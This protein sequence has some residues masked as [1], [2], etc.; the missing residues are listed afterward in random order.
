MAASAPKLT[1]SAQSEFEDLLRS[2]TS[3][4]RSKIDA[5][6]KLALK[7]KKWYKTVVH[8]LEKYIKN[9]KTSRLPALY[10]IDSIIRGSKAKFGV[11]DPYAD[12]FSRKLVK[13]IDSC[14]M[15]PADQPNVKKLVFLW[16]SKSWFPAEIMQPI[17]AKLN[18]LGQRANEKKKLAVKAGTPCKMP[19]DA[20]QTSV[21]APVI[22]GERRYSGIKGERRYSG[23]NG[24]ED[25]DYGS[26]ED[27][28]SLERLKRKREQGEDYGATRRPAKKRRASG[29]KDDGGLGLFSG[30][31][32]MFGA[33][34]GA[35][36]D[37][38]GEQP[39]P[40]R[41]EAEDWMHDPNAEEEE[42]TAAP[43]VKKEPK[44][45]PTDDAPDP[46]I[47]SM[48]LVAAQTD[49]PLPVQAV[50]PSLLPAPNPN[51][52]YP[53]HNS[54]HPGGHN[55][56]H[57]QPTIGL[58]AYEH[59]RATAEVVP[60]PQQQQQP[61][62]FDP[63][64]REN[65]DQEHCPASMVRVKSCTLLLRHPDINP[66]HSQSLRMWISEHV[67]IGALRPLEQH[68]FLNLVSREEAEHFKD[69]IQTLTWQGRPVHAVWAPGHGT[70]RHSFHQ[71]DGIGFVPK[72]Y[73]RVLR[74]TGQPPRDARLVSTEFAKTVTGLGSAVPMMNQRRNAVPATLMALGGQELARSGD[75]SALLLLQDKM[76]PELRQ[77]MQIEQQKARNFNMRGRGR[78]RGGPHGM[79]RGWSAAANQHIPGPVNGMGPRKLPAM[80][81]ERGH[82]QYEHMRVE[83][84]W[85]WNKNVNKNPAFKMKP[86]V[87][88]ENNNCPFGERCQFAH[89]IHELRN[90]KYKTR[91]CIDWEMRRRCPMGSRCQFAHGDAELKMHLQRVEKLN[92]PEQYK[93]PSKRTR[94]Y[95]NPETKKSQQWKK[96]IGDV[97][98]GQVVPVPAPLRQIMGGGAEANAEE[99]AKNAGTAYNNAFMHPGWIVSD[100]QRGTK[101]G[102]IRVKSCTLWVGNNGFQE[103]VEGDLDLQRLVQSFGT[104]ADVKI[105]DKHG[106]IKY[107]TRDDTEK[108]LASLHGRIYRQNPILTGWSTGKWVDK[109]NFDFDRGEGYI[110]AQVAGKFYPEKVASI[111]AQRE[112]R[113]GG[114]GGSRSGGHDRGRRDRAPHRR[115][116]RHR[117]RS[118]DRKMRSRDRR[119]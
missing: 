8:L 67:E 63:G 74:E 91:L 41:D 17:V 85:D 44:R 2:L 21:S 13:T 100:D 111:Q 47:A 116:R 22:K 55:H 23:I 107:W 4:S 118:R 114:R 18:R 32:S 95:N 54:R 38:D 78:G 39:L 98:E 11:K 86:C 66:H 29:H 51:A 45:E 109:N 62:A 15:T 56:H 96:F 87:H 80:A 59:V 64:W 20:S 82:M 27:N 93:S 68:A 110:D 33:T 77:L 92:F 40:Q 3:V 26:D 35:D 101:S 12:R 24:E 81:G 83:K 30:G 76:A 9:L 49:F 61:H 37:S 5:C 97:P 99:I 52:N 14:L 46:A 1:W 42:E 106:F 36:S 115:E 105:L 117:S 31:A 102:E 10:L 104:T 57:H 7:H 25:F 65:Q 60:A 73:I 71:R 119:H 6:S 72:E 48:G 75:R 19:A 90:K 79:G 69:K 84:K 58:R 103:G 16:S 50:Q 89:G 113:E 112:E 108:G 88:F 94:E 43:I 53:V 28:L 34:N 70:E